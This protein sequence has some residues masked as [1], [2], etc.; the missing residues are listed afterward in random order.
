MKKILLALLVATLFV[1]CKTPYMSSTSSVDFARYADDGF[2][3]TV[4]ETVPFDYK[5]VGLITV[6]MKAGNE[7]LGITAQGYTKLGKFIDVTVYD[8][9]DK[10]QSECE[11]L[12]ADGIMGVE[13][14]YNLQNSKHITVK[15]MAI[16]R[17]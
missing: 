6:E 10:V 1:G 2:F 17:K 9:L 4:S 7:T 15:G 3:I 14:L 11:S 13:I 8:A 5:P 12:G 16:K